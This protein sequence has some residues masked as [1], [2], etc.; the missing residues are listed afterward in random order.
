MKPHL[1][2][3]KA[4][5]ALSIIST[6]IP[7]ADAQ[8]F[9]GPPPAPQS[10]PVTDS[11]P[12]LLNGLQAGYVITGESEKEVGD[13]G[14]FSRYKIRFYV[15][16]TT[17]EAK[18]IFYSQW[19]DPVIHADRSMPD[20]VQFFCQNATGARLTSKGCNLTASPCNMDVTVDDRDGN[21]KPILTHRMAHLGYWI[22]PGETIATNVIMIVPL[23]E[24]P[25]VVATFFPMTNT[26]A[27]SIPNPGQP[28][29]AATPPPYGPPPP[30]DAA[31]NW[32]TNPTTIRIKN[33][34]TGTYL[35]TPGP[36]HGCNGINAKAWG[37]DWELLPVSGTNFFLIRNKLQ[38]KFLSAEGAGLLSDDS[39]SQAAMWAV[40]QGYNNNSTVSIRNVANHT[41]LVVQNGSVRLIG[42]NNAPD[43]SRC[44]IIEQ[45]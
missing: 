45:E 4:L 23:N 44:W 34:T 14:N 29:Y 40:D 28:V 25:Q 37:C 43:N 11:S 18:I 6:T 15:T 10:T 16:N 2:F 38:H 5:F 3:Q 7:N 9:S 32:P 8:T 26:F 42:N 39:Q 31:S 20:L 21:G 27:A 41:A 1:L 12:A 24:R 19:S 33:I 30:A 13:K 36:Q 22:R 17:S 35:N